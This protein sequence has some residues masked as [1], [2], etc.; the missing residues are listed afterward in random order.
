MTETHLAIKYFR[1]MAMAIQVQDAFTNYRQLRVACYSIDT[2][3]HH[4]QFKGTVQNF[5]FLVLRL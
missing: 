1:L 3:V 5:T 2:P 4:K